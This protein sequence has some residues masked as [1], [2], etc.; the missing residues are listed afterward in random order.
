[1][2]VCYSAMFNLFPNGKLFLNM[3]IFATE[4]QNKYQ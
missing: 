4:E 1:M 3:I 2:M